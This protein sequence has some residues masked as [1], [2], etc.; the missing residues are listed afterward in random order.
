V[1]ALNGL[2]KND[3]V[4]KDGILV[5]VNS[6]EMAGKFDVLVKFGIRLITTH[7]GKTI[8][9]IVAKRRHVKSRQSLF[10]LNLIIS[11]LGD[12]AGASLLLLS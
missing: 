6:S 4:I 7:N 3:L 9:L 11:H 10:A 2:R 8:E 1:N 12:L 5:S